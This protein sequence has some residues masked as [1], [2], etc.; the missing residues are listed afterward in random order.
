MIAYKGFK[1]DL[2]APLGNGFQFKPGISVEVPA[3]KTASCGFHCAEDPF[4]CLSYYPL[5]R[6]NRYFQVEAAGSIDEDDSERIACTKM[7]LLKELTV[8][9]LAGYG[10]MYMVQHPMREKWKHKGNMLEV[11][12]D[13]AEGKGKDAIAIARGPHPEVKGQ[14][15]SVLGLI[16][17]PEPGRITAAR[18][19]VAGEGAKKNTWYTIREDREIVEVQHEEKAD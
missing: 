4:V 16:L 9:E 12:K 1:G 8:K 14:A 13:K 18:L 10:M 17:E 5:G 11:Q 2:T 7:K 15:G 3:S 6:G 19:F